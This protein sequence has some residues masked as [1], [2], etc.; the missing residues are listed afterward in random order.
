MAIFNIEFGTQNHSF[1]QA[2]TPFV[3]DWMSP[4]DLSKRDILTFHQEFTKI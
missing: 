3:D 4:F 1:R 2:D